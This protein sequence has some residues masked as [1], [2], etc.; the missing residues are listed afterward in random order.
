MDDH[1]IIV[2]SFYKTGVEEPI[3]DT[4]VVTQAKSVSHVM[5]EL[6]ASGYVLTEPVVAKGVAFDEKH[7]VSSRVGGYLNKVKL[8]LG[9]QPGA[10]ST[11]TGKMHSLFNSKA[12]LKVQEMASKVSSVHAEAKRIAVS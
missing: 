8:Q 10:R 4:T 9:H 6:L 2:E 11:G 5:A 3:A 12:G 1:P 7:G